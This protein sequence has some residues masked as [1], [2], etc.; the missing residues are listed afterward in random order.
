MMASVF[1]LLVVVDAPAK[2]KHA[3]T[4]VL[5][6]GFVFISGVAAWLGSKEKT[7]QKVECIR[8]QAMSSRTVHVVV[9]VQTMLY[10]IRG[11]VNASVRV[12]MGQWAAI[13]T[14]RVLLLPRSLVA[15]KTI[16]RQKT[17]GWHS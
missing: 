11:Q 2:K 5:E 13:R 9:N 17:I 15:L 1:A 12:K 3:S 4:I 7:V 8:G 14:P 16:V 10:V 6:M